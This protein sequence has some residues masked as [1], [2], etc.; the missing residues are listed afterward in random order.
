MKG[1]ERKTVFVKPIR[2]SL[3]LCWYMVV[4]SPHTCPQMV[5]KWFGPGIMV[6]V[7]QKLTQHGGSS[8]NKAEA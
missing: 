8:F 2:A 1:A 3:S 6:L 4:A 7:S 5:A